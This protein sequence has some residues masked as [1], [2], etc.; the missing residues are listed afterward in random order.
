[1]AA[2][3]PHDLTI[4]Q[5]KTF[6]LPLRWEVPPVVFKPITGITNTAPAVITCTD[7]GLVDG[8]RV[9]VVSVKGMT[10]INAANDP[11][12]AKDFIRAKVTDPNTIVLNG[13]N[14]SGFKP[15][16]SG[17]YL[18][19]YTPVDMAGYSAR[20]HIKDKVGGTL[21][22]D[23][24]PYVTIDNVAKRINI[25]IPASVTEDIAWKKGVYELEME[26]GG[27]VVSTLLHGSISV[28]R[29]IVT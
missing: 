18:Q 5:G 6:Q 4:R 14:A 1:M 27:S 8:W 10:Q 11:P 2:T 22:L 24:T 7:H 3:K 9:A 17:G 26:S 23:A 28:T 15:Y 29:E 19:Y 21:L 13:V 16:V 12:K 20:L 25:S